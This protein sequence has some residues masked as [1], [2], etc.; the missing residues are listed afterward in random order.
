MSKTMSDA[1]LDEM[2]GALM[3]GREGPATFKEGYLFAMAIAQ[4]K[5]AE[6]MERMVLA[7]ERQ[8]MAMEKLANLIGECI[9]EK[10]QL[11][12]SAETWRTTDF[13]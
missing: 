8:A 1:L 7:Q 10:G 13:S 9:S 11:C 3:T 2:V 5:Q 6:L 12:V 4:A